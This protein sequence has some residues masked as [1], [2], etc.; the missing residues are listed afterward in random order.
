MK[1]KAYKEKNKDYFKIYR[2]EHKDTAKQSYKKHYEN[3]KDKYS[4]DR[5]TKTD[6]CCGAVL[7][8]AD[9]NRHY[10]T[11]KH[12]QYLQGLENK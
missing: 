12:Q 11:K 7:R 5:K 6:C 3:N 2:A 4:N 8:K 1:Q 10:K 9:I